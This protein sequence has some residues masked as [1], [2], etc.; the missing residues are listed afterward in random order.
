MYV[1]G[2]FL[3]PNKLKGVILLM[4]LF[5]SGGVSA[6]TID[7]LFVKG[8][9]DDY[10]S[11][12]YT[13]FK[14]AKGTLT[15]S[16][17]FDSLRAHK[18]KSEHGHK[19]FNRGFT[20]NSYWLAVYVKNDTTIRLPLL[21][22][23][24][25]NYLSFD[26]YEATEGKLPLT[27]HGTQSSLLPLSEREYPVRSTSFKVV[28]LPQQTKL[29]LVKVHTVNADNIYFP[30]DITT[31]QDYL[32]YET[33]Y[34][35]LL[36]RFLGYFTFALVFNILLWF[37][38]KNK[39]HL[40]HAA[41][42]LSLIG[43][44]INEF[45]FDTFIFPDWFY[46]LWAHLPKTL[47]LLL[48][49]YLGINILQIF[50]NQ[51]QD[52]KTLYRLF[53]VYKIVTLIALAVITINAFA[54]P[55]NNIFVKYSRVVAYFL[56]FTGIILIG[57]N[58]VAGI[59][60]K[61]YY[62]IIYS[63]STIFLL[64][65]FLDFL[66]N[67]LEVGQLFFIPPG[68]I[69]VAFTF[70]ILALTVI[71]VFRYKKE[72]NDSILALNE[73]FSIRTSWAREIIKI[74]ELE[75]ERIARDLHDDVGATLSTLKL[76]LSN[77]PEKAKSKQEIADYQRSI[78]LISKIT[79]DV[80]AISHDLLPPDFSQDGLFNALQ[81]RVDEINYHGKIKFQLVTEGDE[82]K[83]DK[84]TTAILIYRIINELITNIIKHSDASEA[85]V[86]LAVLINEIQ[87]I[88]EDNGIGMTNVV[89]KAGIGL[90]NIASRVEF[91]NGEIHI[92]T[93][94]KGSTFIIS[95]P[96]DLKQATIADDYAS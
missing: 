33:H 84:V 5:I 46:K 81:N 28:L 68:N 47:F 64:F 53:R 52:F 78:D 56:A 74:Q 24:Y 96:I 60:K 29:L 85:S 76:H 3:Q 79:N 88:I 61:H 6:H 2:R 42:V 41:Y 62:T 89:N 38:L 36:G 90:K 63:I 27:F 70:E 73:T 86:Q 34:S 11:N 75:R 35:F 43:F 54:L 18:F 15:P 65:A 77:H 13:W 30:T 14:D 66:L 57:V 10:L 26:L 80:R 50:I 1:M 82:E 39:L 59:V 25:N 20:N 92:D 95:I 22:S 72:K 87:I 9:V 12:Y 51:K 91:L 93:N 67:T 58:V 8:P 69:I 17:A 71:F 4:I 7:T 37:A 40:W 44:N 31:V 16:A 45:M 55:F 23:F 83:I 19:V 94:K 32:Q 49:V 48:P 21:W